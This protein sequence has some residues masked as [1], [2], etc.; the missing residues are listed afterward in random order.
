MEAGVHRVEFS[1][2]GRS[3]T[4]G[5]QG[6]FDGNDLTLPSGIY[7]YRLSAGEFLQLKR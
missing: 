3:L 2:I 1:T 4:I 6:G 5:T 7:F